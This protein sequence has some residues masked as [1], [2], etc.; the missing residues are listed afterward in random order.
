MEVLKI[1]ST[2]FLLALPFALAFLTSADTKESL[3]P[4]NFHM[5]EEG[6]L[7]RSAQP[8]SQNMRYLDALG[9]KTILNLRYR[10][11]DRRETKNT[12][13]QVIHLKLK[14]QS[15]TFE[16]MVNGLIAIRDAEKP[17]LIHCLHGSDRTGCLAACY[18]MVFQNWD[19][20][21]AIAEFREEQ[22]GYNYRWFPNLL[23]FLETL[24]VDALRNKVLQK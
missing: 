7:Y 16:D 3:P 12:G 9:M 20:D 11:N 1:R 13:L 17:V 6:V 19:K 21:K 8:N 23:V 4:G 5:L 24:D 22:Y 15:I 14:A 2:A 10:I 18:R